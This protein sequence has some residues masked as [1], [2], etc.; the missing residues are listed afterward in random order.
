[1]QRMLAAIALTSLMTIG[2]HAELRTEHFDKDPGWDALNNR[3]LPQNGRTVTQDFG[4]DADHHDLGG[5]VT[6]AAKPSYYAIDLSK[7]GGGKSLDEKLTASGTFRITKTDGGSGFFFG[8]FNSSQPGGG[9]RPISSLGMDFD[10]EHSGAR[11]AVR[12]I[13]SSNKSCG[14]FITPFI[15][16]KY[17][18]TPIKNDG[19]KY[20][21]RL[22]Y[23]P[24]GNDGGG[25]F[26]YTVKSDSDKPEAF[27]GKTFSVNLPPGF[28]KEGA[29]LDRFGMMNLM[30]PG[31]FMHVH[32]DDVKV[33]AH[34]E[35]F[36]KDPGWVGSSNRETYEE[37]VQVGAHNFGFATSNIAKGVKAG[38]IGGEL[39]RGGKY[40]YYADRVGPLSLNDRLEARG[41]VTFVV[42]GPDADMFIGFFD[43]TSQEKSPVDTGNFVGIHVG[44]PTR[45]GHYFQPWWV[46]AN[47]SHGGPKDG[48]LPKPGHSYEWSLVYDPAGADGDGEVRVTLGDQ[49]VTAPM[50]KGIKAEGARLD[51]FGLLT[52]QT[53]GQMVRI[54]LD[55]LTYT[56]VGGHEQPASK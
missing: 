45:V 23:D 47:G 8:W 55:D 28:R 24:A 13:N 54:Y 37:R 36:T 40:A 1:M 34:A 22:E 26:E 12:M 38:E 21:W 50:R 39:W 30:K 7:I 15:P 53:G 14:T 10:G 33:G 16:G 49:S 41:R 11:L 2:S 44:G 17:R 56:A 52:S 6:R 43:G 3:S 27:E 25:R 48:P 46:T 51:H 4:F 42:G 31:G 5:T 9:G 35:D 18:P 19:T 20:T 29:T 32:F